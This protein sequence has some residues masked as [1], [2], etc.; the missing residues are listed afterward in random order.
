MD[1]FN[2]KVVVITGGATGIGF[3]FAKAFAKDGAHLIIAGRRENRLQ[4][5]VEAIKSLGAEAT[6]KVCDTSDS[7]QVEALADFAWDW[8]GHV[9]VIINNAGIILSNDPVVDVTFSDLEKIYSVNFFGVWYGSAIFGK[10]MIAQG[11][12]AAIYNLGS[13]N[14]LF[15]GVPFGSAYVSTKHAVHALTESLR[16]E[17]PGFIDVGLICPGFVASELIPDDAVEMAMPS[18]KYVDIAMKQIKD[19]KFYIVSHAYNMERVQ[20][21]YNEISEAFST[22]APRYEGDAEYDVRTLVEPILAERMAAQ[23]AEQK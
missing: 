16:E 9:D 4:E 10:R 2:N 23:Q 5:A 1:N 7:S 6:Y 18:D 17:M 15:H 21:R 20:A 22:Y 13:E 12:P 19:G 11:T 8:K 3:S 14:S